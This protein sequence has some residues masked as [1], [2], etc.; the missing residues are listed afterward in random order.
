MKSEWAAQLA[1]KA[2]PQKVIAT[3]RYREA[4]KKAAEVYAFDSYWGEAR[5]NLK[6]LDTKFAESADIKELTVELTPFKWQSSDYAKEK[7]QDAIA[8]ARVKLYE[9][10]ADEAT[11][12]ATVVDTVV[13]GDDVTGEAKI[14]TAGKLSDAGKTYEK[15]ALAHHALG[16]HRNALLVGAVGIAKAPELK[17]SA[18]LQNVLGLAHLQLGETQK[19]LERFGKA[20]DADPKATEPLLNAASLTVRNLGFD[21]TVALL[22]EVIKRDSYNYWALTTRPVAQRRVSDDPAE[23]KKALEDFDLIGG[24]PANVNRPEWQF[25]RCVIAQAVLTNGKSEMKRALGFCED[26]L[27]AAPKSGTM[28][29]ELQTRVNGLKATIEFAQ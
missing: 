11:G 21:K 24:D 20:G 16:Q 8:S 6:T 29:K 7:P 1:E 10:S 12:K 9:L 23:T 18:T 17:E 14:A 4:L 27:K 2:A 19:A 25:N 5:D 22:T 13:V 28:Q 26:A 15:L 3:E